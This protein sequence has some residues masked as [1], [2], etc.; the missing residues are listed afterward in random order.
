MDCSL[1]GSYVHGILQARILECFPF[2]S[3]GDLP[4]LEIEPE[5][6]ALVGRYFTTELPGKLL[7]SGEGPSES[8]PFQLLCLKLEKMACDSGAV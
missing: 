1:P 8:P 2:P 3:P 6:L 5:S 7:N 4:D